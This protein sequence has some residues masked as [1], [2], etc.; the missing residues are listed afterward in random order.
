MIAATLAPPAGGLQASVVVP[1]R[2]EAELIGACLDALAGQIGVAPAAYEVVL[3]LDGCADDT[4]Q[5]AAEA[6]AR[7]PQ[8][9]LGTITTRGA[10]AGAARKAG[11]DVAAARLM[12]VGRPDGLVCST[13][14]DSRVAPDWLAAQLRAAAAGARAIG[15]RVEL[16]DGGRRA[17]PPGVVELRER[18]AGARHAAVLAG[19][20]GAHSEH[21]QFS[22]GSLALTAATYE[23]VG[24]LEPRA[25]LEDEALERALLRHGVPIARPRAVRVTTSARLDGRAPR[26]LARD[27][28]LS[29][30]LS[31]RSYRG[32]DYTLAGLLAAKGPTAVSAI[33]P[34]R[35]VAGTIGGVLDA[36]APLE[37]AGLIDELV[38]VDAA[39]ADGTARL[40]AERGA[41][42]LQEDELLA[43]HGPARGKG[44]AMWRGLSATRGDVV[45]YLDTDTEA[46]D[47]G[48]ALGLLGPLLTDPELML[49]KG[50]FARPFRGGDGLIDPHGGGRVTELL[51][52]PLLNLH[53]PE[54]AG[55]A[56]PL[57]G[58]IAAR[59][60]LLETLPFPVGYGIEI[61]M[62][63]D[64]AR[65]A[66]VDA[67]GQVWLGSRQNRHQSLRALSAMAY[68]VLVAAS[69]RVLGDAALDAA[70]P[71]PLALPYDGD[72]QVSQVA[73]E[74]RPPLASLPTA[75]AS[76]TGS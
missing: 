7:H 49:V 37:A 72:L 74:E 46:F 32:E 12:A 66:G 44:D 75:A 43:A 45:V 20:D 56:Q 28:S 18:Q 14:A 61:A 30:W 23:R 50:A 11:M 9:R 57:A 42:V 71:G 41:V 35:E 39:S 5:R 59:R 13:D 58:E 21:W 15:G 63:I 51:A 62:L 33:L 64:A 67:L 68:A 70:A 10:G 69:A 8:L 65:A 76:A 22:G 55:F 17:L 38:V 29:A 52:R 53:V 3:V 16:D 48:Y 19:P 27:L 26:G 47:P 60:T 36:L 24:G 34:A 31:R 73:V 54:L 2:D 25:A 40:A 1:A 6:G 4:E